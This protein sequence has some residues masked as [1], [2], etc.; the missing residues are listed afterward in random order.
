MRRQSEVLQ[1]ITQGKSLEAVLEKLTSWVEAQASDEIIAA[2]LCSDAEERH[3]FHCAGAQLPKEYVDA[4]NGLPIAM[5]HGSCGTAAFIK[6][7]VVVED[8][9]QSPLCVKHRDLARKHNLQACWSTPLINHEGK[10]RGTFAVYYKQPKRPAAAD[11]QLISLVS[12]TALLA[13]EQKIAETERQKAREREALSTEKVRKSEQ[14]F[15]NL[16]RDATIGIVVLRGE[17]M[18]V[19]MVNEMYGRLIGRTPAELMNKPLFTMIP[20]AEQ[21]FRAMLDDVMRT[22]KTIYL[23][24]QAYHVVSDGKSIDGYLNLIY[25]PYREYDGTISGVLA[26]CQDVTE[27]VNTRK[28]LERSEANFRNLVMQAPV[29]IAVYKGEGLLAEIANDSYLQLLGKTRSEFIGKSLYTTQ[30]EL[31]QLIEPGSNEF[32]GTEETKFF[33]EFEISIERNGTF[34]KC[35]FNFICKPYYQFEDHTAGCIIVMNEVTAQVNARQQ[36][37]L[38]E[39]NV[40]SIVESAPFPIGVYVGREMRIQ[41]A[42]QSLIDVWGKGKDII[43]KTYSEVLP[44]LA[45]QHIYEKLDRVFTTGIP[46]NAKNQRVDLV[47]DGELKPF[48]F[49]YSFTPLYTDDGRIYGVMNTAADIT[50]IRAAFNKL[51]ESEVR[52]RLA[53]EASDLGTFHINLVTSELVASTRMTEIF[54]VETDADRGR[55]VSSLHP[56]DLHIRERAYD[57]ARDTGILDYEARI[58]KKDGFITWVKIKGKFYYDDNGQSTRLVGIVQDITEQKT[59]AE[60]LARKVQERTVELVQPTSN[61]TPSTMN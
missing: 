25:Q 8:T 40:R 57:E 36:V 22:G 58:S 17:E 39:Q 12:H 59:F 37:E 19:D 33:N 47:V 30:P 24:D 3:L 34:E 7:S 44:E 53:I 60:A 61:Y 13:I 55:F 46:Y 56:H 42:N 10:V 31:K 45:D 16:I 43:G 28:K 5:G 15:Q 18:I 9:Q 32:N 14:R 26:L 41:F 27:V 35:Y 21:P 50:P 6:D 1:M 48:Y 29:A 2:I 4:I 49:N 23:N 51:E 38:R 54:D 11:R 52:A 20:D